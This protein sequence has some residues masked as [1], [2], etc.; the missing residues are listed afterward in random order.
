METNTTGE[1]RTDG[2]KKERQKEGPTVQNQT[3]GHILTKNHS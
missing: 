1:G 3:D 2:R